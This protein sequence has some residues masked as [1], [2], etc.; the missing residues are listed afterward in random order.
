M[1]EKTGQNVFEAIGGSVV[2]SYTG[3]DATENGE[4]HRIYYKLGRFDD[5]NGAKVWSI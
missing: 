1:C 2:I 5:L 4:Q 3:Q